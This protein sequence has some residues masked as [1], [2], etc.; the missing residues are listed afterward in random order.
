MS[1]NVIQLILGAVMGLVLAVN[2]LT[3]LTWG[4]WV[5]FGL[6]LCMRFVG[7]E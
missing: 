1:K 3:V 4:F 7:D 5:V 6:A 2:G